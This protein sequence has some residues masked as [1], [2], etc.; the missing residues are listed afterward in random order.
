MR[1]GVFDSGIGGLTVLKEMMK[2]HPKQQYFY[3]GDTLNLPYGSKTK[4]E[5]SLLVDRV[6]Q[7]LI[8]K[9]VDMIIIACGTVSSTLYQE[10]Q[11]KYA[12]PIHDVISPTVDFINKSNYNQIGLIATDLTVKSKVFEKKCQKE[13]ISRNCPK[14]VPIIENHTYPS[15]Q[16][17]KAFEEYFATLKNIDTLVLGCT[18]Y[19]VLTEYI[20]PYFTNIPLINMGTILANRLNLQEGTKDVR[21]YFSKI[22]HTL[23]ENIDSII[24]CDYQLEEVKNA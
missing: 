8:S 16:L 14:F 24:E 23:I 6:M 12:I 4:E 17:D 15:K 21:L 1:I 22:N 19:P 9:N 5:L 18:H 10:L 7:F 13:I 11:K 3:F 20:K 2:V